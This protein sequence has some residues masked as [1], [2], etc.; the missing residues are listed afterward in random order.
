M[1][2]GS[3]NEFF[4]NSTIQNSQ[5][6]PSITVLADGRFVIGFTSTDTA[7]GSSS[8]VRARLF[9]ADDSVDGNDFILNNATT[10]G[11]QFLPSFAGLTDGRFVA[12][13][14]STDGHIHARIFNADG[15]SPDADFQVSTTPTNFFT[16]L[17]VI[18]LAGGGFMATW[19]SGNDPLDPDSG[20]RGRLFNADGSPVGNGFLINTT[21]QGMQ[22]APTIAVLEGGRLLAAWS[23]DDTGDTSGGCIRAR[24][25]N[26]D[27]SGV[28]S[29]FIA[30]TTTSLFQTA[31]SLARLVEGRVVLTWESGDGGDGDGTCIRARMFNS[32]GSAAGTDF[33]VN[34]TAQAFQRT[35]TVAALA[36][37]RF[38]IAWESSDASPGDGS[39]T[40]IRVRLYNIDGTPSGLDFVADAFFS[41]GN[42]GAPAIAA[43]PDGRFVV[44]FS[45][46]SGDGSGSCLGARIFDPTVFKGTAGSDTWLG[47]NLADHIYGGDSADTLSGLDGDDTISGDKGDDILNGGAGADV[48]FGGTGN[49]TYHVDNAADRIAEGLN[50]GTD[51]VLATASFALAAGQQIEFLEA[52]GAAS[53]A[54][55]SLTGNEFA[56]MIIGDNGD[57]VLDGGAGADVLQGLLGNDTYALGSEATGV[58]TVV[59]TG[60]TDTITSAITRSL[61]SYAG[62]EKLVLT[63]A[64]AINGT[65]DGFA[66]TITGNIAANTLDGGPGN[67]TLD[68]GGG[69]DTLVGGAGNDTFIIDRT[70]DVVVEAVGAA[71]GTADQVKFTG[72]AGQTLVLA[73]NV[74]ILMLLG[75]AATNGRGNALANTISGNGAANT[76]DGSGGNDTL[77]ALGGNDILIGGA[78]K[79]TMTSGFGNDVF[80]FAA[81]SDSPRGAGADLITDFDDFGNDRI[82][83]SKVYPGTLHY[84]HNAAFSAAGQVRISDVPGPD[85]IVEVN[86]I[87]T[88]LAE[89]Q[90]RL[91][92]TTLASMTASDF[93]L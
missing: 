12:A 32:D 72:L 42:Q 79:D 5:V 58:D 36:D 17:E 2:I 52:D 59:D 77:F 62:I 43:L 15:S 41:P 92:H 45:A 65:G 84:I 37:G 30:N 8:C 29:D 21:I 26:A 18:G 70:I 56:N 51:T 82:D 69:I 27:G 89:M 22:S 34:S 33:I 48:L 74:E 90:I 25:L 71:N 40:C 11:D 38:A 73:N 46:S 20:I 14:S 31:P 61:A 66:N 47:G 7:D 9:N 75:A 81:V 23:S 68:G 57:N 4:V 64:A 50:Q 54:P 13:F 49:D 39:G 19:T 1:P 86:T 44:S 3:A 24:I 76:L 55:L 67:D 28:G 88:S 16:S 93:F 80:R 91:S 78:G 10:S 60:G 87:G 63:G 85:I 35:P 83:L 6:D 53:T